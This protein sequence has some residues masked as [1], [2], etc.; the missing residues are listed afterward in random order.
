MS[1]Q[2][3][4]DRINQN[5]ANTYSVLNDAGATAPAVANSENLPG[6]AASISAV[7]YGKDQALTDEQKRQARQNIGAAAT[8]EGGGGGQEI[9]IG[10]EEPTDPDIDLWINPDGE[11]VDLQEMVEAAIEEAIE[12]GGQTGEPGKPGLVQSESEPDAYED[13]TYPVWLNPSGGDTVELVTQEEMVTFVEGKLSSVGAGIKSE[14]V[15]LSDVT[16][17][18]GAL[19]ENQIITFPTQHCNADN[20]LCK[21]FVSSWP[22]ATWEDAFVFNVHSDCS[23]PIGTPGTLFAYNQFGLATMKTQKYDL[24]AQFL[25]YDDNAEGVSE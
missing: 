14:I 23:A 2:N 7:L 10:N 22:K 20:Y 9:Y 15:R 3:E 13:G 5:I 17:T 11:V 8:G 21:F 12:T 16:L 1:V 24:I 18:K 4:I 25:Y 19:L 6:T